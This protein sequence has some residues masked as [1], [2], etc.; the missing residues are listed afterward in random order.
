MSKRK[1]ALITGVTGQDGALLAGFLLK[2]NYIVHGVRRRSSSIVSSVRLDKIFQEK[3]LKKK[4]FFL[5]YGDVLDA[6]FC[7][8]IVLKTK[9]NEI[10]H[11]A[12]QS[13][14]AISFELPNYTTS[15]NALGTLNLLEAIRHQKEKIRFYNAATSEMYGTL[16]TKYQDENTAFKPQSPY[17]ISKLYSYWLTKNYRESYNLFA[18]N[19]ILFNHESEKRG[20]TFVTR[21]ISLFIANYSKTNKGVLYLGNLNSK[22]DWGYAPDYVEGMW[23][24]LNFKKADDFV[25]A[26]GKSYS[27]KDFLLRGFK[28]INVKIKFI[29]K[30]LNEKAIDLKT[31][32][33]VVKSIKHYYRPSEVKNLIGK[34]SK[35]LKLLKWKSKTSFNDLVKKMILY[36]IKNITKK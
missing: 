34:S 9:P 21:K 33:T 28:L 27:V 11:L 19:G 24:I 1:I 36:D 8:E 20:E 17:A 5:H 2:K 18:S 23:K 4:S 3:F 10:Y 13:H 35:A 12:A 25:L 31:K 32:K 30:G 26:T 14:V 15:T 6:S 16:S 29:G 22:R 7:H